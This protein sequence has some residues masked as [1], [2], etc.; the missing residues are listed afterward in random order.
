MTSSKYKDFL[1]SSSELLKTKPAKHKL[2]FTTKFHNNLKQDR[3][4]GL[5]VL[6]REWKKTESS[7]LD[8][9]PDIYN[10]RAAMEFAASIEELIREENWN[11]LCLHLTDLTNI[12]KFIFGSGEIILVYITLMNKTCEILENYT[13]H[14][15][16]Y[17]HSVG[18]G[19]GENPAANLKNLQ[20]HRKFVLDYY[21]LLRRRPQAT[22]EKALNVHKTLPLVSDNAVKAVQRGEER[23]T[24][25]DQEFESLKDADTSS[26]TAATQISFIKQEIRTIHLNGSLNNSACKS[27]STAKYRL[28]IAEV[29]Y[30]LIRIRERLLNR[31]I[32]VLED[33]LKELLKHDE[34]IYPSVSDLLLAKEA[35][36]EARHSLASL[37]S[38][39]K[40]K[41]EVAKIEKAKTKAIADKE[42][43]EEIELDRIGQ[44]EAKLEFDKNVLKSRYEKALKDAFTELVW[45]IECEHCFDKKIDGSIIMHKS[46]LQYELKGHEE[47]ITCMA[48]YMD[49]ILF[50]GSLDKTIRVWD[51]DRKMS[52]LQ[53]LDGHTEAVTA[54]AIAGETND[55]RDFSGRFLCSGSLDMTIRL[56]SQTLRTGSKSDPD[57]Q[58]RLTCCRVLFG[59]QCYIHSIITHGSK[60]YSAGEDGIIKL[61]DP[62]SAHTVGQ[63]DGCSD[64]VY[65]LDLKLDSCKIS[66]YET[67]RKIMF[68]GGVSGEIRFWDLDSKIFNQYMMGSVED[69]LF[70][71]LSPYKSL[72]DAQSTLDRTRKELTTVL[73][74]EGKLLLQDYI[75]TLEKQLQSL[76]ETSKTFSFVRSLVYRNGFIY[77]GGGE[78]ILRIWS[79]EYM[80]CI[81][82]MKGF[83]GGIYKL[84]TSSDS[85]LACISYDNKVRILSSRGF[86]HEFLQKVASKEKRFWSTGELW[87]YNTISQTAD[88][89]LARMSVLQVACG[90][91]HGLILCSDGTVW[92]WGSSDRGQCGLKSREIVETPKQIEYA[93]GGHSIVNMQIKAVAAGGLHSLLLS[94]GGRIIAFG[95]NTWG[96]LGLPETK[97]SQVLEQERVELLQG[98]ADIPAG[99]E[100]ERLK[101]VNQIQQVENAQHNSNVIYVPFFL[102]SESEQSFAHISAAGNHS[103]LIDEAGRAWSCGNGTF[104]Q[105]GLEK[106][107]LQRRETLDG[108][109]NAFELYCR[110]PTQIEVAGDEIDFME[111]AVSPHHTL[112]L[113]KHGRVYTCGLNQYGQLGLGGNEDAAEKEFMPKLIRS[114]RNLRIIQA[115][116][117][118]EHSLLLT[119]DRTVLGCGRNEAGVLG[120]SLEKVVHKPTKLA[121]IENPRTKKAVPIQSISTFHTNDGGNASVLVTTRGT[122]HVLGKIDGTTEPQAVSLNDMKIFEC[123]VPIRSV[124]RF[125]DTTTGLNSPGNLYLVLEPSCVPFHPLR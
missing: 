91:Y 109:G 113:S 10:Q 38:N 28:L 89:I 90:C 74:E 34:Q 53:I 100:K 7:H 117:G 44:L 20:Q 106:S 42:R 94:A 69:T 5:Y 105:L 60:I 31:G 72:N 55:K 108:A 62:E 95:D 102:A 68:S 48:L 15:M 64:T 54:L 2:R 97:E 103:I 85:F 57:N 40:E 98:L 79:L 124:T 18:A 101:L 121:D 37:Q 39:I 1:V 67:P 43:R 52:C 107:R 16:G 33:V 30:K 32:P 41:E 76:A 92:V 99:N 47:V 35:V 70:A 77:S 80:D 22:L 66:S 29:G 75:S 59:H 122:C 116:A 104:G 86:Q 71:T 82:E 51:I 6:E 21:E 118:P 12:R 114:I 36:Q 115:S 88:S 93:V 17:A 24:Y 87:R 111:S 3:T 26:V 23:I 11:E 112:L 120:R 84:A 123:D 56:W 13:T 19:K 8:T 65:A 45:E 14:V 58:I 96:Q 25:L 46:K 4:T 61:W 125:I 119:S 83:G 27:I 73:T 49:K 50:S 78:D 110:K 9:N 81:K 63:I